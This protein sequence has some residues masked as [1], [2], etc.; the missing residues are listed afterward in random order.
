MISAVLAQ[1]SRHVG[2]PLADEIGAASVIL[3]GAI[4]HEAVRALLG[5]GLHSLASAWRW[6]AS[7]L[8]SVLL[9]L[10]GLVGDEATFVSS[11]LPT[12][13][14]VADS[15]GTTRFPHTVVLFGAALA[16]GWPWATALGAL[17]SVRLGS[18]CN[19][20]RG[21]VTSY[22]L[23]L[24]PERLLHGGWS[25]ATIST[26][27]DCGPPVTVWFDAA[28]VALVTCTASMRLRTPARPARGSSALVSRP[29][30]QSRRNPSRWFPEYI[31]M[32]VDEHGHV[33]I[34][35]NLVTSIVERRHVWAALIPNM[36]G[37]TRACVFGKLCYPRVSW[38]T[39][40]SW[41]P[42]H[43]PWENEE[44]KRAIGPKAAG[45]FLSGALEWVPPDVPPPIIVEPQSA[46][47]K[48]GKD[49][50]RNVTDARVGNKGLEEWG[51]RYHS[52]RDFGD[53]L[54]PCAIAFVEDVAE[55]YHINYLAGCTGDLVWGWGIVGA[56]VVYP[57]DPEYDALVD[58]GSE[59][60]GASDRPPRRPPEAADS[61]PP[62]RLPVQKIEFGWKLHV[63]CDPRNC[64]HSCDKSHA[65]VDFDGTLARWAVPHFGQSPAGSALNAIA[66]CLLRFMA[67]RNPAPGERRG[68][69]VR[70]GNGVVWVDD[71]AFWTVVR[72]HAL[73]RGLDAGCPVCIE[74]L[75]HAQRLSREWKELC[76]KLGVPLSESK[77]QAPS[78]RPS[79][80]G[81]DF[82]SVR[83]LVLTQPAKLQKLVGC[84]D[85]WAAAE[86]ITPR[87]LDSVQGRVL[88][89]SYAIRYL[90]I[91]ATQVY[92]LL[93]SVP[94]TKYDS[95]VAVDDEMRDLA[96]EARFI[97]ERFQSSGRPLW[98]RVPSSLYREFLLRPV[99]GGLSFSLTW[100]ASP[101][102]WAAVLRWW[103]S[104]G[105]A[106]A[107]RDLLLVGTWPAGEDVAEQAHRE[108]LAAPLALEA[109]CQAVDLSV[110]YGLL[111]NDAE[112]AIG[113]L[114]KGSTSS[115]PMQRQAVR[116]NRVAYRQELDL[117]LA[118]VPGLALVEEGIDGAS[119]SG[120][121]FG[122][123]AN[124][125][126]VLGPRVSDRLWDLI[127]S[128]LAPLGWKVTIDL[129]AS[130]SNAR[131]QRYCSRFPEPGSECVDAL[132][133]PDWG[134]SFCPMCGDRHREVGY[135]FPPQPLIRPF[136]KKA[137]ADAALCV[138]VVPVAITAPYWHKLVRASV[139]DLRPA[140]DGFLRV[141]NPLRMLEYAA[142]KAPQELAVFACDFARLNPRADLPGLSG[143][144]GASIRRAR[145]ACR[146]V[147][148]LQDRRRLREALLSRPAGW[149][150]PAERGEGGSDRAAGNTP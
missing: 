134:E 48:Q 63:G 96:R 1:Q 135:A 117:V 148:D 19:E 29:G 58:E 127:E 31:R 142:G 105:A 5:G 122:A 115:P 3:S 37:V 149:G 21:F 147:G 146:T 68:A 64:S 124:L 62:A 15:P 17:S 80:A 43:K 129:F 30:E 110:R 33:I 140:V 6:D 87:E 65:G 12:P 107:L 54:S 106:P 92:C 119:R 70:T 100:D 40:A 59:D 72:A 11:R 39:T 102:G 132:S 49:V 42:N 8:S 46:V 66:L 109:A 84:L 138:V 131:A 76:S 61:R 78:Q 56:R 81:F 47:P 128:L 57:G 101:H 108:A 50:F 2:L 10:R 75:P 133:A 13:L 89:Y 73:C 99:V 98:P 20:G 51:V 86:R 25:T 36:D 144:A 136:V 112:A 26:K 126:H 34:P 35:K 97:V 16:S 82:D 88:H 93:G 83:G 113:A 118:H 95:P 55:A 120:S 123:D 4:R 41:K 150:S 111:R 71:F 130:E 22:G 121:Q 137:I 90:R 60:E 104:T 141:R 114:S 14:G 116:L 77:H 45:W 24:P 74:F 79:Y 18:F 53:G 69:S 91:V 9:A 27:E 7:R 143:C 52:A 32:P 67:A 145:P 44:A 28:G 85:S 103:D 23:Q 139:L 125:E 38:R 94:E